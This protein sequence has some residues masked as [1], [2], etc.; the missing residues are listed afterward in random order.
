MLAQ[1]TTLRPVG[2]GM[3]AWGRPGGLMDVSRSG[4]GASAH[5]RSSGLPACWAPA[6]ASDI[7]PNLIHADH[8]G[9]A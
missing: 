7:D 6:L 1:W 4:Q 3:S 5:P 9:N 2:F 8:A